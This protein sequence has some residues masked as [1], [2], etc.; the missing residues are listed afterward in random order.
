MKALVLLLLL[1][2]G[3]VGFGQASLTFN[4]TF[5]ASAAQKVNM[6]VSSKDITI[7]TIKGSRVIVETAITISSNNDKLLEF[8]AK[9][10]RYNLDRTFDDQTHELTLKS[11]KRKNAIRVKGKELKEKIEYTIYVPT[12]TKFV[13]NERPES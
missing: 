12:F 9:D 8:M 3:Q 7:K 1:G 13:N 5:S 11:K 2:I 6:D 4:Q 10:G